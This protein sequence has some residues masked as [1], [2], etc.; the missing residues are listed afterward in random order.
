MNLSEARRLFELVSS[1]GLFEAVY[2]SF[3]I[4]ITILMDSHSNNIGR[5]HLHHTSSVVVGLTVQ[6]TVVIDCIASCTYPAPDRYP[7]CHN[8]KEYD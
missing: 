5:A 1:Y 7:G 2:S 4:T 6:V 8:D 3:H